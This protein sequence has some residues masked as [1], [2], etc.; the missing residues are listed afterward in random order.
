MKDDINQVYFYAMWGGIDLTGKLTKCSCSKLARNGDLDPTIFNKSKRLAQYDKKHWISFNSLMSALSG[1]NVTLVE[2][3]VIFQILCEYP[4]FNK[5]DKIQEIVTDMNNRMN[6]H[7][8]SI[9]NA[10]NKIHK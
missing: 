9:G 6:Y 7:I 4:G 1:V 2:Y 3:S 8:T 10:C 5:M